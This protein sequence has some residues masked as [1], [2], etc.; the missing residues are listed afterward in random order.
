MSKLYFAY[1]SNM[2]IQQMDIRCPDN[3]LIGRGVLFDY[4][5]TVSIRGY[6][7]IVKSEGTQVQG[8][9]YRISADDEEALDMYEGVAAKAY[10]KIRLPVYVKGKEYKM[11][12][13]IDPRTAEGVMQANYYAR[14][15][16]GVKDANIG[17]RYVA[18]YMKHHFRAVDVKGQKTLP[19]TV[20]VLV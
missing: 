19:L 10:I 5:W 2:F 18:Q 20:R 4:K 13:Y 3:R 7:N 6:A 14:I 15:L 1:G 16:K 17:K 11:L 8:L 9:V 12:V